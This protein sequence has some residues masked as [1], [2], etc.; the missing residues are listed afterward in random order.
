MPC[1]PLL[2]FINNGSDDARHSLT[3]ALSHRNGRNTRC[4]VHNRSNHGHHAY[5]ALSHHSPQTYIPDTMCPAQPVY[6]AR[7]PM[8]GLSKEP[9][10]EVLRQQPLMFS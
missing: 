10:P 9:L 1:T 7:E 4:Y 8:P 3:S 5:A 6:D 2:Y